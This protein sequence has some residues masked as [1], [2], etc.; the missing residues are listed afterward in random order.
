MGLTAGISTG[1]R[2]KKKKIS[3]IAGVFTFQC[4]S[5]IA[6]IN[7]ARFV[8]RWLTHLL[9]G[10]RLHLSGQTLRNTSY[11]SLARK[12]QQQAETQGIC[13]KAGGQQA[14]T[15]QQQ[16]HPFQQFLGWCFSPRHL[17]LKLRQQLEALTAQQRNPDHSGQQH[18]SDRRQHSDKAADL[19]QQVQLCQSH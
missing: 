5:A 4:P 10:N 16:R 15:S 7:R 11:Q 19:D 13:D 14:E 12:R 1:Q 18:Q 6:G 3:V 9:H 8:R 2:K 17:F